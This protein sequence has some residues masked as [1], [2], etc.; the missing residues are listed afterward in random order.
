MRKLVNL[1]QKLHT[2]LQNINA[3]TAPDFVE[4]SGR[5][6]YLDNSVFVHS[7]YKS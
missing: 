5:S 7:V 1:V 2:E 3:I 6:G 4:L